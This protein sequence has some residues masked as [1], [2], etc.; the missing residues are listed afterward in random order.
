MY[1]VNAYIRAIVTMY[2]QA[3]TICVSIILIFQTV[4]TGQSMSDIRKLQEQYQDAMQQAATKGAETAQTEENITDEIPSEVK[5]DIPAEAMPASPYFGYNFLTSRKTLTLFDNIP[6]PKDYVLGPGDEVIFSLW[7]ETQFRQA[8]SISKNGSI[9]VD[10]VGLIHLTGKSLENAEKHLKSLFGNVFSTLKGKTPSTYLDLSIGN[11][12]SI[13]VLFV[14][15]L[16]SP[17]MVAIHPFS[18]VLTGLMQTG[19]I[20]TSGTL[21]AIEIISGSIRDTVDLYSL[22]LTGNE[23]STGIR[24]KDGDIVF[25]P[26]RK[27]HISVKGSVHRDMIY[28][29]LPSETVHKML[30]YAGGPT[31]TSGTQIEIKRILPPDRRKND[32]NANEM[33]YIDL[34]TSQNVTILDGDE[35]RLIP[36]DESSRSIEIL[37]QV[38]S[39]GIYYFTEGMTLRT[40]LEL[41]GGINDPEFAKTIYDKG[42]IIRRQE[43]FNYTK[44]SSFSVPDLLNVNTISVPL[45][46]HDKIVLHRNPYYDPPEMVTILGEV[47]IPGSYAIEE[48]RTSLKNLISKSGGY[49]EKAFH[50]GITITRN[51]HLVIWDETDVQILPGDIIKVPEKPGTVFVTGEVMIGGYIEFRRG[52]SMNKYIEMAGG[53]TDEAN[54]NKIMVIY[55]NGEVKQPGWLFNPSIREGCTIRVKKE[56]E[57][58]PFDTTEFLKEMASITASLATIFFVIQSSAG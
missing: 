39:P 40:A 42:E 32:D 44:T 54:T 35:I 29:G 52:I 56:E 20:N 50:D 22:L 18:T 9:Y 4:L 46:N 28:E 2:K 55:P 5:I 57:R 58:E 41:A 17:G 51:E 16:P 23:I 14:G 31:H 45:R 27:S 19:G 43:N 1:N 10:K 7:G 13:N 34:N 37:G 12:K 38:K 21:R 24:L 8:Y 15:E 47:L 33:L 26:P 6:P 49:T 11:L 25:V 3:I 36:Y 48:K 53:F 30:Q